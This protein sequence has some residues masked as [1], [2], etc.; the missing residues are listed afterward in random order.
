[1]RAKKFKEN[2]NCLSDNKR[3]KRTNLRIRNK[4]YKK[5]NQIN[6]KILFVEY[7]KKEKIIL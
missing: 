4:F 1:M 7:K 5:I 2:N 3:R 6:D